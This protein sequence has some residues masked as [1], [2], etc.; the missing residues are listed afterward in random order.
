MLKAFIFLS[1]L[2]LPLAAPARTTA[3]LSVDASS[4]KPGY[5]PALAADQN[6]T[7]AWCAAEE[8]PI[9]SP[10]VVEGES[11]EDWWEVELD[12][13]TVGA[14]H[15][16]SG[17]PS[18]GS[19]AGHKVR[20]FVWAYQLRNEASWHKIP[21]TSRY[22]NRYQLILR[23]KPVAHV[24]RLRLLIRKRDP[25][26]RKVLGANNPCLRE[27]ALHAES[28]AKIATTPWFYAVSTWQEGASTFAPLK[29]W[30]WRTFRIEASLQRTISE[31]S[32]KPDDADTFDE[33]W[34]GEFNQAT[35]LTLEPKPTAFLFSGNYKDFE[36]VNPETF[37]GFY[38]FVRANYSSLPMFGACGGHQLL[39]MALTHDSF[40]SFRTEFTRDNM[41]QSV[42][43]CSTNPAYHCGKLAAKD[44]C[45]EGGAAG[46]FRRLVPN[47][48][49]LALR[50]PYQT[51]RVDMLFNL[52]AKDGFEAYLYHSDYVNPERIAPR[53]DLIATYPMSAGRLGREHPSLVQA[54]KLKGYPVYGSQFH[55]D[56]NLSGRCDRGAGNRDMDRVLKNFVLIALNRFNRKDSFKVTATSN[57]N[58]VSNL[59]DL[60][61]ATAWC[62]NQPGVPARLTFEFDSPTLLKTLLSVEGDDALQARTQSYKYEYSQDGEAWTTLGSHRQSL[63]ETQTSCDQHTGSEDNQSVLTIFPNPVTARFFRIQMHSTWK[64]ICL[65]ELMLLNI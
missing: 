43:T 42:I 60:D 45:Y 11:F 58:A 22:A 47:V 23:F 19:L 63:Y 51:G 7:T 56:E 31:L 38:E 25:L 16:K 65:R 6:P 49:G 29:H 9:R 12:D 2:L 20:G 64:S 39:A 24:S 62:S 3:I 57:T 34:A 41:K 28:D 40:K 13:A 14:I 33:M 4:F 37:R 15:M 18:E 32:G 10:E 48:P 8:L 55:F 21:E 1:A 5:A 53:F 17:L 54:M 26:E 59:F 35:W 52:L 27:V 36:Q 30:D 50:N 61:R 46:P 44:C